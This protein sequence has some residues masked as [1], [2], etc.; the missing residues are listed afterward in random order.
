[1]CLRTT[2][3]CAA[4]LHAGPAPVR[5]DELLTEH[6]VAAWLKRQE[7]ATTLDICW[8]GRTTQQANSHP[9]SPRGRMRYGPDE[10][11]T[12][13]SAGRCAWDLGREMLR[14][15]TS[16]H[17]ANGTGGMSPRVGISTYVGDSSKNFIIQGRF[18]T[19]GRRPFVTKFKSQKIRG[20]DEM[21]SLAIRLVN[22]GVDR[23]QKSFRFA[24]PV[25]FT[26]IG[27]EVVNGR[28]CLHVKL[29]PS[30]IRAT[31]GRFLENIQGRAEHFWLDDEHDFLPVSFTTESKQGEDTRTTRQ[32][33]LDY[34]ETDGNHRLKGWTLSYGFR[35]GIPVIVVQNEVR[36][37]TQNEKVPL[38]LFRYEGY[39]IDTWVI[40]DPRS[41][42]RK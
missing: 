15:E 39:P 17:Y 26:K 41:G 16:D 13:R 12:L 37:L 20:G 29:V 1:M 27:R 2:L 35:E 19:L 14:I 34:E 8:E 31:K 4:L 36:R 22:A 25:M 3:L 30:E 24:T 21:Q 11:Q 18:A 42:T 23:L 33:D 38:T 5:S 6:I 28:S 7:Q 40:D 10:T 9:T 32:V